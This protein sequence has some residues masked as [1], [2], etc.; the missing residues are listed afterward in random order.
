MWVTATS[1]PSGLDGGCR[2]TMILPHAPHRLAVTGAVDSLP[3]PGRFAAWP[4]RGWPLAPRSWQIG[5]ADPVQLCRRMSSDERAMFRPEPT[6]SSSRPRQQSQA[7]A[8]THAEMSTSSAHISM[9][10]LEYSS[11]LSTLPTIALILPYRVENQMRRC[12]NGAL[13]QRRS[14]L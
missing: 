3:K 8:P 4:E 5:D 2:F 7:T 10:E 12:Q 9:R 14:A 1:V 13:S 6:C 11:M